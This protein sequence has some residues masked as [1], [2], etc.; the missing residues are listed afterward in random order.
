MKLIKRN[1][2][3]INSNQDLEFLYQFDNFPVFMGCTNE[4]IENDLHADMCWKISKGSGAI[5]LDPLLPLDILYPEEHG[6]GSVGELWMRHHREFADFIHMH[7]PKVVLEIGGGHGILNLEYQK[8]KPID[9]TILEPNPSPVKGVKAKYIK[10][11]FDNEFRF[12]KE[13]DTVV[14]SHVFEHVYNPDEFVSHIADFL[15]VGGQLIFTL[16]N[17]DEMLKRKYTNCINFEHTFFLS[18][19]YIEYLL[20]KYG[21]KLNNK[22]Y[23]KKDH[24]IFYSFIKAENGMENLKLPDDI[25]EYNRNLYLDYINYHKD[26][27][28]KLNEK[29]KQFDENSSIFLFGAHV[30]AQYLIAFGLN[31]GR[32][33]CLLDN[34]SNKHGKRLY[35]CNLMV[36]SPKILSQIENPVVILKAGVYDSEIKKDILDNINSR[37]EFL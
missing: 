6:A 32:V 18:E 26:L 23:F 30:F 5:Q 25:Y 2:D 20:N 34:D 9:W 7:S 10:G 37:T 14:H 17:M 28:Q 35:G 27:I 12:D 3:V 15:E 22:K 1:L 11:F 4:P 24:S 13:V 19:P 29:I 8:Y 36:E 31:V 21:F 33:I 16:P